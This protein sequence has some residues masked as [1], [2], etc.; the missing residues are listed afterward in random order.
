MSN[1]RDLYTKRVID[2]RNVK[3]V[4]AIKELLSKADVHLLDVAVGYFYLS[5]LL[6]IKDEF[7]HF[8]TVQQGHFNILMGNETN[9][10]TQQ[11]FADNGIKDDYFEQLSETIN[12]D[13]MTVSDT[14]FL[15]QVSQWVSQGRI[16][17]KVYTGEANYFHA[18]SYLFCQNAEGLDGYALVGSSN[19]S[20]NGLQGNTELNVMSR[21]TFPVLKDWF[22]TIWQSNEVEIYDKKLIAAIE[23]KVPAI[24]NDKPYQTV[25]ETYHDYATLFSVPY[26]DLDPDLPW[27]QKLYPH[28]RSGVIEISD[29]LNTF[30]TAVLSD[31]VGL[32]KTRTTAGVIRLGLDQGTIHRVLLIA[33][34]KLTTQWVEEMATVD[35]HTDCFKQM[36]RQHFTLLEKSELD[37]LAKQYDMI[38]I[39]EAHLGF[40]SRKAKAYTHLQYVFEA[41]DEKIKGLLLTA[42][43][44][45]NSREDVLNL[46]SLFLSVDRIP[47][48]RKYRNIFQFGNTGKAIRQLANDN[49]AFK[50]FWDDLFLQRTRKTYGGKS[51]EYAE[52]EFPT[53]EIPYEPRKNQLFGDNFDR[54][55]RLNFAYMDPIRYI[56]DS[57]N[58]VGS[59]RLKMILLK[60]ADSSWK[61]YYD[62]L[63]SIVKKL[64]ILSHKLV[65][66]QKSTRQGPHLR[67]FLS[68]SYKLDDYNEK[69]LGGLHESFYGQDSEDGLDAESNELLPSEERSNQQKHRY[70]NKISAQLQSINE[71]TAKRA[72]AKM[73]QDTTQDLTILEP[74]LKEL[75]A[76]YA[77]RDEKLEGV[78]QHVLE[79]LS[80]GRKVILISSFKTTAEYYFN[81]L[82]LMPEFNADKIGLITGGGVA[83]FIG[84]QEVSRKNILNRFSP[85]SKN[86]VDLIDSPD[87]IN[88]LIGTDTISTGQ[89]LQDAQVIMNLDLPYNP[90]VLEQRIG[91]IDRPR[92]VS[93]T[94]AIY[95]YTFPVY[96]TID[97]ELKMS[98]RLGKKMEGVMEDTQFDNNILPNAE[99]M[100]FLKQVK[101]TK[102]SAVKKM[103]DDTVKKTVVNAGLSSE[104]HSEQYQFAN[105]RMYDAKIEPIA[106]TKNP[107]IPKV[108]FS[109]GEMHGVAVLK[110]SFNDVNQAL[111]STKN[112]V[113]D[114]VTPDNDGVTNGEHQLHDALDAGLE[115]TF[116]LDENAAKLSVAALDVTF[117]RVLERKVAKY[118]HAMNQSED[119]IDS[120]KDHVAEQTAKMIEESVR[121]PS[122]HNMIIKKIQKAGLTP[123]VIGK[124]VQNMRTIDQ[125]NPL[126]ED[127]I[128]IRHDV[129][130]FWLNFGYYA[131]QFDLENIEL[132]GKRQLSRMDVR[133]ADVNQS[134]FKLLLANVVIYRH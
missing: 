91:R 132:T 104:R 26:A 125:D 14:D 106:R 63:T 56:G 1:I 79:E 50:Q 105:R 86:R 94:K 127:V 97:A 52:R 58:Q 46:G 60:R 20:N 98:E 111:L 62:S 82:K 43:P 118:N 28:Q 67:T 101:T 103:L 133:Q 87:E 130:L 72:V 70:F 24:S 36:T 11:L 126:Y 19:F 89:N 116:Q 131:K 47:N 77:Q 33:D 81:K 54:I 39:D 16:E 108:S 7:I 57:R 109:T 2:N 44:W 92:D 115:S 51:V 107:V 15:R 71:R 40:K 66:I 4:D 69:Q 80:Q 84:E 95:V 110:L 123:K 83:N 112:V 121:N 31:G 30:G 45:N 37:E 21:D 61:A 68:N 124:L 117:Q 32:G 129:N 85:R 23:H 18:K 75:K 99:Y 113:V 12:Q 53:I 42:T 35:V 9:Y 100:N 22:D 102:G 88:L 96:Q 49:N 76:A 25:A 90:M 134:S 55:A 6:L 120:L 59:D 74:L 41:S 119:V 65:D 38:V 13:T 17:V 73:L 3:M 5:G 8:M 128:D 48:D 64:K 78:K 34:S 29:K 122:N 10:A 27:V 93:K 114:L